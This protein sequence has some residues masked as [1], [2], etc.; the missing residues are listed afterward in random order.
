MTTTKRFQ[1]VDRFQKLLSKFL[2]N[3][4]YFFIFFLFLLF[5]DVDY[6][7]NIPSPYS[8]TDDASYYFH[9]D[10]IASDFDFDYSNQIAINE[11]NKSDIYKTKNRY[12]PKHPIGS[13]LFSF[14]LILLGN[15]VDYI[16]SFFNLTTSKVKYFFYSLSPLVYFSFSIYLL[17]K[18][19]TSSKTQR[20]LSNI[21]ISFFAFGSGLGYYVFERH[22]MS[23]VYE[24]FSIVLIIYYCCKSKSIEKNYFLI[25]FLSTLPMLVRWTNISFLFLPA[26]LLL[27]QN[28]NLSKLFKDFKYYLGLIFGFTLFLLFNNA[29]YEAIIINPFNI[30]KSN[31]N[32]SSIGYIL[33]K[34][35]TNQIDINYFLDM[36]DNFLIILFSQ[37]FGI[38]FFSP[39]LFAFFYII[40]FKF[41]LSFS[42]KFFILLST[43]L[44]ITISIVWQSTGSSYGYR[45]L[46]PLLGLSL[47]LIQEYLNLR[48]IKFFLFLNTF[49]AYS[50]FAFETSSMTSLSENINSFGYLHSYSQPQYLSGVLN[51]LVSFDTVLYGIAT[52]LLIVLGIKFLTL[53]SLDEIVFE[54]ITSALPY[55]PSLGKLFEYAEIITLIEILFTILIIHISIKKLKLYELSMF[56]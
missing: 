45:Y 36:L 53:L 16:F 31:S 40:F 47:V 32:L 6:R 24:F 9:A 2:L 25:G 35:S 17:S 51:S 39:A 49:S 44:P 29:I 26:A 15:I 48:E 52:S 14:P 19:D 8:T 38:I 50:I 11:Q 23:H 7:T 12:V 30:Y 28:H 18:L 54:F 55:N 56:R 43:S 22:S 42:K 13:G 5:F 21:V 1:L 3:K 41:N 34:S 10:T 33:D 4:N 37:E 27:I 20:P 46:L